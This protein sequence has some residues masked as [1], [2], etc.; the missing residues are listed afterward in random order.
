M[1]VFY[2]APQFLW[3]HV[4]HFPHLKTVRIIVTTHMAVVR[5]KELI[6]VSIYPTLIVYQVVD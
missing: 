1:Y 2:S 6:H 5:I 4:S 3:P